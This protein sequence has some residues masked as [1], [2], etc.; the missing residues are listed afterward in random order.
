MPHSAAKVFFKKILE[1]IPEAL[2]VS[3][4][5]VVS[6]SCS[7]PHMTFEEAETQGN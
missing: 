6:T 7:L 4:A 5:L 3:Q 2:A 1:N